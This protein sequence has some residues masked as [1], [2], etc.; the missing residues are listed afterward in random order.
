MPFDIS[1]PHLMTDQIVLP[2]AHGAELHLCLELIFRIFGKVEQGARATCS[3]A[4]EFLDID[5]R[6]VC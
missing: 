5:E 2:F 1:G 4:C 3:V 6:S